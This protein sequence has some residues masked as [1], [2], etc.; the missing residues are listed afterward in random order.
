MAEESYVRINHCALAICIAISASAQQ[1]SSSFSSQNGAMHMTVMIAPLF[2]ED[3]VFTSTI[4]LVNAS[5]EATYA[6]IYARSMQ[7][8]ILVQKR[9]PL[10]P[11]SIAHVPVRQL[12]DEGKSAETLGSIVVEQSP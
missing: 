7:G 3:E 9:I 6:T 10:G 4:S 11:N 8:R 5:S 1:Q 12:L 2:L